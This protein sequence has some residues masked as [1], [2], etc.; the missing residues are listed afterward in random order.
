[1]P[2][3][4]TIQGLPN[5]GPNPYGSQPWQMGPGLAQQPTQYGYAQ[6]PGQGPYGYYQQQTPIG[7]FA[8]ANTATA[9]NPYIGQQSQGING[10][11]SVMPYAQ[12]IAAQSQQT[13]PYLG[14]TTQQAAQVGPNAYAGS[15]PYL[16]Q[17]I[18]GTVRN[19]TQGFNDVTNPQFDRMAAASGSFGN[20]GVE[21]ARTRAMQDFGTNLAN[22]VSGM[23]MQ[24]YTQQQQLAENA[25]NRQQATNQFNA[26]LN[27]A[28][29]SRNMAGA[30][31]GQGIGLQGL[32]QQLGAAQFDAGNNLNTQQFNSTLGANDLTRNSSLSQNLGMFNA[33]AGNTAN[34]FNASAG[35]ALG[36]QM[37]GLNEQGRQFDASLGQRQNE[38]DQNIGWQRD[39]FGQN[40]DFNTWQA[41]NGLQRQGTQDQIA[42]INSLLG[43]NSQGL[44][45]ANQQQTQPLQLWQQLAGTGAQLGG[46][47][48]SS[49]QNL[50]GNPILGAIGGWLAGQRMFGG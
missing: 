30:F 41:N 2:N 17:A 5:Q 33:G 42:L 16:D 10:A 14:Q 21:T 40:M 37:R 25:L 23:R 50:Q 44:N 26:G 12:Q 28:D 22:T 6:A 32:G 43:W 8:A 31:Q 35:N 13:N 36:S 3:P 29:L 15:N 27:A 39:M 19:A 49:T 11:P 48:A 24:D 7:S 46:L 38:F 1:M 45:L 20:T 18:Q 4:Y 47:G 9:A 34:M